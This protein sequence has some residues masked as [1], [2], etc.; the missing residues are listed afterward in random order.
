MTE[1]QG[2]SDPTGFR[3]PRRARRRRV[4]DQRREVVLLARAVRLVPDRH[5][6]HRPRRAAATGACRCSSCRP[7]PRASRS[8]ATSGCGGTTSSE[9]THAYIRYND[10]RMPADHLLGERGEGFAVAQTRLGGGRIHHAMRTV[11]LVQRALD[12]MLERARS[13]GPRAA[14]RL[15][16]QQLVQEMIADSWIQLEQFRLLVLQTAWKIDQYNDYRKV[17]ARHLR[18]QGGDAEGAAR[19]RRPGDPDP[20]LARHLQ[21][22]AVRQ[23]GAW[24]ASTWGWPTAPP[25]CTRSSSPS[26]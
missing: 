10:V 6:G 19:R 9:G 17:I 11:G 7:T 2:G 22:D 18:G 15:A 13:R 26:S 12:M 25:S 3:D 23:V 4:G 8:S 5:G 16:D 14:R 1:P 20:R 24:R 21:R